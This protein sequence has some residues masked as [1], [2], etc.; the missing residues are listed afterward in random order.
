MQKD[1]K[2]IIEMSLER[3]ENLDLAPSVVDETKPLEIDSELLEA[4]QQE[5]NILAI[6]EEEKE[7]EYVLAPE[8]QE[9]VDKAMEL[10]DELP[11]SVEEPWS[12]EDLKFD[13]KEGAESKSTEIPK[14]EPEE[15]VKSIQITKTEATEVTDTEPKAIRKPGHTEE[16][17]EII[18]PEVTKPEPSKIFPTEHLEITEPVP[19][20]EIS[21]TTLT[22]IIE[23]KPEITGTEPTEIIPEKLI[24]PK[25]P[26]A[27]EPERVEVADD[28]SP[29]EPKEDISSTSEIVVLDETQVIEQ[30]ETEERKPEHTVIEIS[31]KRSEH[32]DMTPIIYR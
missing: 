20:P 13:E 8:L 23:A 31:F 26:K 18:E 24:E 29:L 25:E 28:K 30:H 12:S 11:S 22:E 10:T 16:P 9:T 21:E 7:E 5:V 27:I 15:I 4:A 6:E 2:M 14:V 17:E 3:S 32:L 1:E 19:E